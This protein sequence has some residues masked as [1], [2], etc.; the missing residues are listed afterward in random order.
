ME[1]SRHWRLRHQRYRLQGSKCRCGELYFPPRL[2]C[3][4]C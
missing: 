2:V 4:K 1:I 3:P